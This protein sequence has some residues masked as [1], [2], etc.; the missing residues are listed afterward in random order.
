M[1]DFVETRIITAVKELLKKDVNELLIKS[2][3]VT[4]LILFDD[5][6]CSASITPSITLSTCEQTEKERIIKLEAYSL[7]VTFKIPETP[8]SELYCYSYSGAISR[9]IY[10]N[11]T[12]GGNVDRVMITNKKYVTPKVKNCG[13]SWE[14]VITMRVTVEGMR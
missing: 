10:D 7:T 3:L 5:I 12:L 4:P 6:C 2:E 8:E 13:E 11:P 9:A 14:L 1:K